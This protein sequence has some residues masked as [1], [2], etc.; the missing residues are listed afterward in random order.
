MYK[1]KNSKNIW[2][3]KLSQKTNFDPITKSQLYIVEIKI[4]EN[5]IKMCGTHL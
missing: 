3:Q 5:I 1:R 2:P 4:L